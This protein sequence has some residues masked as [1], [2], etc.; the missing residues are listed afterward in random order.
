[1]LVGVAIDWMRG[2]ER[3][4]W[5]ARPPDCPIITH[6][7]PVEMSENDENNLIRAGYSAFR[8]SDLNQV[9]LSATVSRTRK[10]V[11]VLITMV[12]T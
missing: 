3:R 6:D 2:L 11:L 12:Q 4:V 5:L 8:K 9:F 7:H 10:N 1:M